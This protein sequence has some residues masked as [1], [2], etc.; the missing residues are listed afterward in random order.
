ML[1]CSIQNGTKTKILQNPNLQPQ[2]LPTRVLGRSCQILNRPILLPLLRRRRRGPGTGGLILVIRPRPPTRPPIPAHPRASPSGMAISQLRS[3]TF[4]FTLTPIKSH[5]PQVS[6]PHACQERQLGHAPPH[7]QSLLH[8]TNHALQ[9]E[10]NS[11]TQ[12][13]PLERPRL[14]V[15]S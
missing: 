5:S 2:Q 1:T 6:T 14:G 4:L 9:T 8:R 15:L 11:P 7:D 10:H 13:S 3:Q 12:H